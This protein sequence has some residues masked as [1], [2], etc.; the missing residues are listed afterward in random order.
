M[1]EITFHGSTGQAQITMQD[2][3]ELK[4]VGGAVSAGGPVLAYLQ[5]GA[6]QLGSQRFERIICSGPVRIEF[7]ADNALRSFGPFPELVIAGDLV[8]GGGGIVARYRPLE[9]TWHF[10]RQL[11][12]DALVLKSAPA[13]VR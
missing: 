10:D 7:V 3:F 11:E 8:V 5:D 6:W 12:A 4:I 1:S 9:E 13:L 2:G